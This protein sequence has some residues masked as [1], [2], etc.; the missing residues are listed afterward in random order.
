MLNC[1]RLTVKYSR[2]SSNIHVRCCP[3]KCASRHF[4]RRCD[5]DNGK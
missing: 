2:R 5:N 3:Q 4:Q 1:C